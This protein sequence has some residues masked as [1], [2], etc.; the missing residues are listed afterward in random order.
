MYTKHPYYTH[1]LE[2]PQQPGGIQRVESEVFR[3]LQ[4]LIIGQTPT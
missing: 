3:M 1:H 2:A 4:V